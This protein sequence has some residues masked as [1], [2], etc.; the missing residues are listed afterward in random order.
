MK[1]AIVA[2]GLAAAGSLAQAQGS[3]YLTG[4]VD[5]AVRT[6]ANEGLATVSSLVSGSNS[7]SRLV[8]RGVEDLGGGLSASFHL[9]HGLAVDTGNPTGGFW[10]RRSTVSLA[11]RSLGELR[12]GRDYV[13]SYSSWSRFDPFSHVG[14]AS[15]GN[16]A[17][18]SQTG[19]IRSAFG[20]NPN[21]TVRSSNLVEYWLPG[22]IGGFEGAILGGFKEGGTAATGQHKLLGFRLGWAGGPIDVS[23]AHTETEND[24]IGSTSFKDST[25]GASLTLGPVRMA[26]AWRQFKQASAKQSNLMLAAV[27]TIGN[28]ELKG[29]WIKADMSGKVGTADIGDNDAVQYGLGYVHKLSKRSVAYATASHLDNA[30]KANFVVPGGRATL[31]GGRTSTGYEVGVRHSF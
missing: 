20:T 24:L 17:A 22:K 15:S 3:V 2:A 31:P 10:D 1:I 14:V 9:E 29:S 12:L 19:P 13:P 6:V 4:I 16:L 30:G 23:A 25:A 11:S 21:T 27:L 8:I 18:A 28:G 5:A 26:A 7:T